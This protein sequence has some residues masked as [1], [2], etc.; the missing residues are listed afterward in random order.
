MSTLRWVRL[1]TSLP[2]NSKMLTLL[3]NRDGYRTAF[4]YVCSLAY[5]GE[6]G[7]DG[8]IPRE[9]LVLLH[10]RKSDAQRLVEVNLWWEEEG[11]WRVNDWD[12]YQPSTKEMKERS[13][14]A[15]AAAAA[16]WNKRRERGNDETVQSA[17]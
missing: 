1:D 14:R 9:A 2:R 3:N 7:T 10:A 13:A 16:R 4:V 11:G 5:V 8:F 6:Q 12:E 17:K 15:R